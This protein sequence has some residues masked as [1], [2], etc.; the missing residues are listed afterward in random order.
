MIKHIVAFKLK[1]PSDAEMVKTHLMELD[2]AVNVIRFWEVGIN[3]GT[4]SKPYDV[5]VYS[6]E[7]PIEKREVMEVNVKL[8]DDFAGKCSIGPRLSLSLDLGGRSQNEVMAFEDPLTGAFGAAKVSI[9]PELPEDV[10][11]IDS[12][13]YEASGIGSDIVEIKINRRPIIPIQEATIGIN[14]LEGDQVHEVLAKARR[15]VGQLKSWLSQYIVFKDLKLRWKQAGAAIKILDSKPDLSGDVLRR[16]GAE[17]FRGI[18][19]PEQTSPWEQSG[20]DRMWSHL[21]FGSAVRHE[22]I[23]SV[24]RDYQRVMRALAAAREDIDAVMGK[25]AARLLGIPVVET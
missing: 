21:L 25:T 2:G 13:I 16:R 9:D 18:L 15:Y 7:P 11:K 10:I 19:K 17:F 1:N 6:A 8:V 24:E 4:S 20:A 14:P 12:E 3:I 5:V 22:D 23:A